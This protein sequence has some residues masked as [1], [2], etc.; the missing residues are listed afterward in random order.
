MYLVDTNIFVE[1]HLQQE[2]AEEAK[3]F[4]NH[5][6]AGKLYCTEFSIYSIGIILLRRNRS[7]DFLKF[8]K[9]TLQENK[10]LLLRLSME[11]MNALSKFAESYNLDFDDAYQY[12]IA[13][14]Y[15]LQLVSFD[16]DFDRTER[17]RV[18]PQ[19]VLE[20]LKQ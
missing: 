1:I 14:N 19:Q 16:T 4:L 20:R 17:G 13:E 12:T 3:Q 2:R 7:L 11:E 8:I 10:V 5:P 18:T 9:D 15:D 6:S